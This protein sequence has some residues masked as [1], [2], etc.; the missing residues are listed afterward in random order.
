MGR[1]R[2][3]IETTARTKNGRQSP[4]YK[5]VEELAKRMRAEGEDAPTGFEEFRLWAKAQCERELWFLARWFLDLDWLGLGRFHRDEVCPFLTDLRRSRNKLLMLPMGHLKSSIVSR[6]MPIHILVQPTNHNLYFPHTKG[7]NRRI[8]LVS[9]NEAKAKEN[10]GW[11][12]S[13]FENNE[14]LYWMWPEVIWERPK[15]QADR[16]SDAFL[17]VRRDQTWA[18]AS[19]TA[20]GVNT[21]FVGRYFDVILPDDIAALEASQSPDRLARAKTFRRAM[22]TRR[23]DKTE[24]TTGS[25]IIGVGTEWPAVD[26]YAEW[27]KDPTVAF[28]VRAIIEPDPETKEDRSLWPEKYPLDL[29]EKMRAENDAVEWAAWYM[30]R[31]VGR[32]VTALDWNMLREYE[33]SPDGKTLIFPEIAEIDALITARKERIRSNMGFRVSLERYDPMNAKPRKNLLPG[34]DGDYVRFMRL[35]YGRCVECGGM[36]D[37]TGAFPCEHAQMEHELKAEG[38]QWRT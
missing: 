12:R 38:G 21:G 36:R 11:V 28:L 9:E 7:A 25:I 18:E 8:A 2:K 33:V 23:V 17:N 1:P 35:K 37:E 15:T 22:K 30:N 6:A 29:V 27:Q 14:W 5:Q 20:I 24:G 31:R 26:L 3:G 4:H 16:W 13:H 10:V 34:M 32:G 19:I